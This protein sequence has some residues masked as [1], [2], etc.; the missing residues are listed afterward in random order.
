M[1]DILTWSDILTLA[2]LL[3]FIGFAFVS[4]GGLDWWVEYLNRE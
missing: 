3:A 4:V 1:G 2:A